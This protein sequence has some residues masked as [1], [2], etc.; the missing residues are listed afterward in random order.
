MSNLVNLI[1]PL[2]EC[3]RKAT[4]STVGDRY[5]QAQFVT[6]ALL[7][8]YIDLLLPGIEFIVSQARVNCSFGSMNYEA[9]CIISHNYVVL[10]FESIEN[11]SW[12]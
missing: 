1:V 10:E 4:F 2:V 8:T 11:I 3:F 9:A 5:I 6:D 12:N 7:G